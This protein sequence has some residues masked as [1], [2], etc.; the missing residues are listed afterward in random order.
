MAKL[1]EV[2]NLQMGKTPA[3]SETSYWNNGDN[4]WVSIGDMDDNLKYIAETKETISDIAVKESNIKLVPKNTVIMSFKLSIG[5]VAIT[6]QDIYTNEAIMALLPKDKEAIN[7]TYLFYWVKG[8]DWKQ[9]S[10]KAVKGVTLNKDTLSRVDIEL[11]PL[12]EQ[13]KIAD[14]LDTVSEL[15]EF[16]RE[17]LAQLDLIIKS[18]F[19]ELFGDT[20]LSRSCKDWVA[21]S[22]I[23]T[24]IGGATP[25][26][27]M[28]EYWNGEY[29][30]ISP[31]E[32]SNETTYIFDSVRKITKAGVDSCSLKQLPIGTVV[33]S[34]RAPIG[35]VAIAG[36]T[37][38][39]NQG[40][41]NVV[42]GNNVLP[43]FLY[44]LLKGNTEY[45]NSL[46]RGATFKEISK[47]I[48]ENIKIPLPP[49]DLQNEFAHFVNEVEEQKKAVSESIATLSMLK[50]SLMQKYFG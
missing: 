46:G 2:F 18:R 31:A 50:R 26:T 16:R 17:Q 14:T 21:I 5:K 40:F 25:K 36:N 49:L 29:R 38:Y 44:T 20:N 13:E 10:N 43:I 27:D 3:R 24:V 34:S 35:K 45:L 6:A 15:I 33:L 39:C 19:N 9:G 12:S 30:W 4:Y 47:S 23:G 41:K 37:F 32:I 8:H 28:E 42:C 1:G 48:V 22:E 11:P 7:T